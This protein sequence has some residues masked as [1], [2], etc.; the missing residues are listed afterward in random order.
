M[1]LEFVLSKLENHSDIAIKWFEDNYMKMNS[2]KY[3]LFISGHKFG[4]L[5]AKIGDDKIWETRTVKL[6]SITIDNE[7]IV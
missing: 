3:H 6:L 2:D 4:H 1:N 7:L 5:W